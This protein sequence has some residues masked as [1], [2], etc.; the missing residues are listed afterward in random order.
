MDRLLTA[1]VRTTAGAGTAGGAVGAVLVAAGVA[2]E[3]E[4]A[5][6]G[7]A[8][9]TLGGVLFL[10]GLGLVLFGGSVRRAA[11]IGA[12]RRMAGRYLAATVG[13][14]WTDR[15]GVAGV[16]L[17]LVMLAPAV[18]VQFLFGS[19]FGALV[20]APGIVLFWG[21]VALIVYARFRRGAR[22]RQRPGTGG[23]P[24]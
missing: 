16:A 4:G 3:E 21:G 5:D 7:G 22:R 8:V 10:G 12:T 17:G 24:R 19:V 9:R 11:L 15:A 20:I 2:L 18:V 13:W 14:R 23:R 6:A 1:L